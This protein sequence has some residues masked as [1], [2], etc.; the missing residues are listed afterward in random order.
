MRL[1]FGL[2]PARCGQLGRRIRVEVDERVQL[3]ISLTGYIA[4]AVAGEHYD[5]DFR[6]HSN[7]IPGLSDR[8]CPPFLRLSRITPQGCA[9]SQAPVVHPKKRSG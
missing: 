9:C 5:R 8:L 4:G 7:S 3:H 2:R 1:G 6:Q